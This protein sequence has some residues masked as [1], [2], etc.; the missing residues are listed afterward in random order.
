[1]N[2][3]V[4]DDSADD[5]L[6]YRRVLKSAFGDRLNLIEESSGESRLDAVEHAEPDCILFDYFQPGR[7]GIGVL[8]RIRLKFP[9]LPI[10]LLTGQGSEAIAVQ[11]IWEGAQDYITKAEITPDTL[12]P[13]VIDS[14]NS[15]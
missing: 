14:D 6:L 9:Y 7:N 5:R 3:F 4:I 15:L 13:Y 2:I 10:I 8:K 1:L 11:S 12:V